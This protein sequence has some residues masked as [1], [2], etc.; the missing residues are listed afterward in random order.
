[1]EDGILRIF[2]FFQG[3]GYHKLMERN[4]E[5][6]FMEGSTFI[7]INSQTNN[8]EVDQALMHQ[9][10]RKHWFE[11][12]IGWELVDLE[13]SWKLKEHYTLDEPLAWKR[14]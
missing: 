12:S 4:K 1:M 3:H 13:G 9:L 8:Y 5:D 11:S 14:K 7:E 10:S 2:L 6:E